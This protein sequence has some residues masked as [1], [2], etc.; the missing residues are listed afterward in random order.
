MTCLHGTNLA[1]S[2]SY[3]INKLVKRK[4]INQNRAI[5]KSNTLYALQL[6][7]AEVEISRLSVENIEL[8]TTIA[9][10][11]EKIKKLKSDRNAKNDKFK[12]SVKSTSGQL[13]EIIQLLR[14]T[15]DSLNALM[16]LDHSTLDQLETNICAENEGYQYAS[17]I[18]PEIDIALEKLPEKRKTLNLL[19]VYREKPK[20]LQTIN[21]VNEEHDEHHSKKNAHEGEKDWSTPLDAKSLYLLQTYKSRIPVKNSTKRSLPTSPVKPELQQTSKPSKDLSPISTPNIDNDD[22]NEEMSTLSKSDVDSKQGADVTYMTRK[23]L[24]IKSDVSYVEPSLRS[25][26]RQGD[27]FTY[28]LEEAK[29]S[30]PSKTPKQKRRRK[31]TNIKCNNETPDTQ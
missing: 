5:I 28:S 4:H 19:A 2:T 23:S 25:K 31:T 3:Y 9:R 22:G 6:R 13:T 29:Y 11:T 24:R 7:K 21:E 12:D 17:K 26:L 30:S 27:P 16:D 14:G 10:L 1:F 20:L 8:R 18:T 15:A